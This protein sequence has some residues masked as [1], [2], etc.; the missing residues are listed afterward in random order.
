[1]KFAEKFAASSPKSRNAALACL[2]S[3]ICGISNGEMTTDDLLPAC[4]KYIDNHI[5][6]LYAF[7][8]IRRI[9]GPSKDVLAK[10]LDYIV[11]NYAAQE[12]VS[13]PEKCHGLAFHTY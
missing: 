12:K 8:D 2:D 10:M 3:M 7:N 11:I 6:K 9:I 13:I 5:H 1:M 4:Q